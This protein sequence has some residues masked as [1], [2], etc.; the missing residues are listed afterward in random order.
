MKKVGMV[1]ALQDEVMPLVNSIGIQTNKKTV[2]KFVVYD[3]KFGENSIVCVNS[4]V[5]EVMAAAATQYL[6]TSFNPDIIINFGVC[7][8]LTSRLPLKSVILINGV[9]PYDFDTSAVD[10]T[11][12]GQ[13]GGYPDCVIPTSAEYI[14]K[15]KKFLPKKVKTVICASADKFVA[16]ERK[17][18][19]LRRTFGAK[20]CDMESAGVLITAE[21]ANI[22]CLIVKAVSDGKG[23]AKQYREMVK[24]AAVQYIIFLVNFVADL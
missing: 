17:K 22:P 4:G 23:G 3:F 19:Y 15:A 16:D 5:G 21:A 12:V 6:I 18:I 7:G 10:G 2:G 20:V 24:E 11:K 9:V 1:V 8:T 14:E 13:Y